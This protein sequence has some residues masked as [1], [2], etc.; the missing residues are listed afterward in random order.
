MDN[1]NLMVLIKDAIIEKFGSITNYATAV[2][3]DDSTIHAK[4]KT[5]SRKFLIS[6]VKEGIDIPEIRE[7][8]NITES[9]IIGTVAGNNQTVYNKADNDKLKECEERNKSCRRKV[10]LARIVSINYS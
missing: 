7:A 5:L 4:L 9:T 6:L 1:A 3:L 8:L 10:K 2:G